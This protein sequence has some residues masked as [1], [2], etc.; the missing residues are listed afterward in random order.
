MVCR[1]ESS[2]P[3]WVLPPN[4]IDTIDHR[5][6][7]VMEPASV[8]NWSTPRQRAGCGVK[9]IGCDKRPPPETDGLL[10]VQFRARR[11]PFARLAVGTPRRSPRCVVMCDHH[12][13]GNNYPL[14]LR[15][16]LRGNRADLH[17]CLEHNTQ[18]RTFLWTWGKIVMLLMASKTI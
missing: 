2:T 8:K 7:E 3:V 11:R 5:W 15:E 12:L 13:I 4:S 16:T 9:V 6:E 18:G 10:A 1:F 17:P 14:W